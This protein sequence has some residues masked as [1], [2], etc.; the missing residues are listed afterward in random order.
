MRKVISACL[1]VAICFGAVT[2]YAKENTKETEQ[3]DI[4]IENDGKVLENGVD[5]YL[6][7]RD[8]INV[9]TATLIVNFIGNYAGTQEKSFNIIRG[10]S[11]G[12]GG[13]AIHTTPK[14]TATPEPSS[15]P[16]V[17]PTEIPIEKTEHT[18]YIEGYNGLF[19][20]ESD[21][22]RAEAATIF[23][24]L[25][26]ERKNEDITGYSGF[27]DIDNSAW[28]AEYIAYLEKYDIISGYDDG[29]FKPYNSITR[30]EFTAVCTRFYELFDEISVEGRNIFNDVNEDYWAASYI[31]VDSDMGWI[32]GYDDG[33]FKPDND[34]TRAEVV[35]IINRVLNRSEDE[36]NIFDNE[37]K[38]NIFRD[39]PQTHW[40]I[41]DILEA[42]NTHI[43]EKSSDSEAWSK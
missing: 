43:I 26:S 21:M 17:I 42:C 27:K 7:Y 13:S 11:S 22:T 33:T 31:F 37:T 23:A 1:T 16:T 35:T 41:K 5:Y 4:V 39:V 2:G 6:T 14:P 9:G 25:V 18:A 8:N 34:I 32:E 24:R 10:R 36:K 12:G 30:A 29:T 20:P 19:R 3:P 38:L 15:M 28:Y 40:A